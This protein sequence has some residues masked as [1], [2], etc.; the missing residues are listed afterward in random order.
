MGITTSRMAPAHTSVDGPRGV[1][2]VGSL[3]GTDSA[4]A[5]EEALRRCGAHLR[6]VPDGET[7]RRSDW[8]SG[9]LR[10]LADHPD[11]QTVKSGDISSYDRLPRYRVPRHHRLLGATMDLG[12]AT[13]F[14]ESYPVFRALRERH[15][16]PQL[17]FQVGL[18]GD[19]DLALFSL[20]P[21]AALPHRRAFTELVVRELRAV[22]AVA[23][24]DV[25]FQLELPAESVLVSQ[26]P[27]AA[28]RVA[29]ARLAG[30]V[31]ALVQCVPAGSRFGVHLCFG[32]LGHRALVQPEDAAPL[33]T[34]ANAIGRAWPAGR[35]LDYV[36]VPLAAGEHPPSSD[37]AFHAPLRGLR[38]PRG[39][40]VVAGFIHEE[41]DPAQHTRVLAL[42]E[43][44]VG[45]RV[46]VAAACGLG[47]ESLE[48]AARVLD[49]SAAL[50]VPAPRPIASSRRA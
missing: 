40:S 10:G 49:Q 16:L 15:Q 47:R 7:G 43:G 17:R 19:L 30:G 31:R 38:L 46:D 1:H 48:T 14:T 44:A 28:R 24:D 26:L 45:G 3:P 6:S 42:V 39:T 12:V 5:M 35:P 13:A 33:V 36:H 32:D 9:F 11:L 50:C 21:A 4:R 23:G 41:L 20:G 34:L 37:P 22:R 8:I 29:A 27:A 25:V 2:L 18:A